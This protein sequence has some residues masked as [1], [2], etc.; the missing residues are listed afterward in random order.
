MQR[1]IL[2]PL[3]GAAFGHKMVAIKTLAPDG[4]LI[5]SSYPDFNDFRIQSKTFAGIIAFKP[6]PLYIGNAP[7]TERVWVEMV[8]NNFFDVLGVKLILGRPFVFPHQAGSGPAAPYAVISEKLWRSRF[9]ATSSIIGKTIKLNQQTF[10][11]IGVTPA[12][13]AGTVPGL[14][15]DLYVPLTMQAQLTGSWNWLEDRDSRPLA[16]MGRLASGHSLAEAQAELAII[17]KRLALTYPEDRRLGV[18]V[19]PVSDSPDG[20]QRILGNLLR[21]LLVVAGAVLLIVCANVGNLLLTRALSREKEFGI[22]LSLG[23]TRGRLVRQLFTEVFVLTVAAGIVGLIAVSWLSG[24]LGMFLP[25]TDL[26]ISHFHEQLQPAELLLAIGLCFAA[27]ALCALAPVAQLFRRDVR[28]SLREASRSI[29]AGRRSRHLHRL[30]VVCEL[31]LAVVALIGTGLFVRSFE[32]ARTAN[33]GFNPENVLL[34]GLDLSQTRVSAPESIVLLHRIQHQIQTVPGV[35]SVS[36]C[37]DVPLGFSS[38]SWE[39]VSVNGYAPQPGESMKLWRNLISPDYFSTLEIPLVAGR[40]FSDRDA[41]GSRPVA[42]VN[43]TF[44][45]RF[46]SG[47]PAV[48]RQFHVWGEQVTIVGVARDAKY[49]LLSE[50]PMPY[51]YLPIA[52]FYTPDRGIGVEIRTAGRP[53]LFAASLRSAIHSVAPNLAITG[54]ASFVS[55]M[56]ASYFTQKVGANLLGVLGFISL[57]LA[58]LGLYGVIAYST[59]QRRR[60]IGIRMAL[61]ARP[62]Q[63]L[64]DVMREGAALC[65]IGVAIGIGLSLFLARL[66]ASALY[67][68]RSNDLLTYSVGR[69]RARLLW[70]FGNL[71]ASAPCCAY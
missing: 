49:H 16:L 59:N 60:E 52:Q 30:F 37:E 15:F 71:A 8:S 31:S 14:S 67:G 38:G 57:L 10:T 6:R 36:L 69:L 55:Y 43:Q 23:A 41:A 12:G 32:N 19:L 40:D 9:Q 62:G 50:A 3:P 45:K 22:R 42:I 51:F 2:S 18:A 4:S 35:R 53:E 25:A 44:V 11:I 39:T 70:N 54:T 1:I 58:V 26:P 56:S 34:A 29:S 13:F 17:A 48:G 61:G 63:V 64:G 24:A 46:L 27:A 66:A 21:V 7:D 68:V 47:K 20:V 33:P 28:D 65:A 5:D